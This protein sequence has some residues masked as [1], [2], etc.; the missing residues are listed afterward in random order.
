MN[1]VTVEPRE[2]PRRGP[3]AIDQLV[4]SLRAV[5][6]LTTASGLRGRWWSL[7]WGYSNGAELHGYHRYY[8]TDPL[9]T[10]LLSAFVNSLLSRKAHK[11]RAFIVAA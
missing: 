4:N 7:P 9:Y 3:A 8:K 2:F 5:S 1:G 11:M 6:N 10:A